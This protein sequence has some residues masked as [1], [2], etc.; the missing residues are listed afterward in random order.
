MN[1]LT[2]GA[3]IEVVATGERYHTLTDWGLAIGNND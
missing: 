2:N 1:V 3:T